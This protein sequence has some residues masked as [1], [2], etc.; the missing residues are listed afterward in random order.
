M[1]QEVG[2]IV[3]HAVDERAALETALCVEIVN[4]EEVNCTPARTHH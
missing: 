4:A 1:R 3:A 2:A